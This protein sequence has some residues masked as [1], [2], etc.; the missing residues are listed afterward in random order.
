MH[1]LF[2]A[3]RPPE[4]I[5][6][7][8]LGLM[9]G[10]AEARWQDDGQIHLTLRFIGEV[11]G[12]VA[13]DIA[14]ALFAV[15]HSPIHTAISGIGTF[16]RKGRIDALW[17][18]LAPADA[19][20]ALHRKIDHALVRIGLPPEGRAFHPHVTLARFSRNGGDVSHFAAI[21]AGLASPHFRLDSFGLYE[22]RL[23][24]A[25]AQY[26]QVARYDLG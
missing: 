17:A 12:R 8:L 10:V 24:S 5:R 1:R 21:H 20:A 15:H 25:G 7:Q 2:V 19:L 26:E 13:E 4:P 16:E 3:A 11:D 18:G 9:H 23:G 14:E 6:R 22:S